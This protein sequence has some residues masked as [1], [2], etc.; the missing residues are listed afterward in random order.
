MSIIYRY[1]KQYRY[2]SH[3]T[4]TR[5]GGRLDEPEVPLGGVAA[6]G[7]VVPK[8]LWCGPKDAYRV[9]YH[10]HTYVAWLTTTRVTGRAPGSASGA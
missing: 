1:Y 2:F 6:G 10:A 9:K 8:Y 7:V 3:I 4:T 5:V